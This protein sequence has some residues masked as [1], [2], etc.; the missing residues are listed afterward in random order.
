M[1]DK[2][3]SSCRCCRKR[4][5]LGAR[6]CTVIALQIMRGMTHPRTQAAI[7]ETPNYL[8]MRYRRPSACVHLRSPVLSVASHCFAFDFDGTLSG[9]RML[10]IHRVRSPQSKEHASSWQQPITIECRARWENAMLQ[11]ALNSFSPLSRAAHTHAHTRRP[12]AQQLIVC[13]C[14]R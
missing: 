8:D 10:A 3:E 11:R 1:S 5:R 12:T 13:V 14:A 6:R 7:G 4:I 2:N 9:M